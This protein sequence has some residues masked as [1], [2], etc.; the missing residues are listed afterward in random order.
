MPQNRW[1]LGTPYDPTMNGAL[2]WTQPGGP[3]TT[4]YPQL[5]NNTPWL[6]YPVKG[7]VLNEYQP[8]WSPACGH[9]IKE[10]KIIQ[11]FDAVAGEAVSLI[12]CNTCTLIQNSHP[13]NGGAIADF[14]TDNV[15]NPY[16]QCIILG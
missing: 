3:Y 6:D 10:W 15:Y 2:F 11:E 1:T 7:L 16:Q 12:C 13:L 5:Q 9:P 8:F 4:V 14:A